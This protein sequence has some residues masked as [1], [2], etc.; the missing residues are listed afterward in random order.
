MGEHEIINFFVRNGN[1]FTTSNF[2]WLVLKNIE[3]ILVKALLWLANISQDFY[4]ICFKFLDFTTYGPVKNF[5]DEFKVGVVVVLAIS[6][7]FI[8]YKLL[9]HPDKKSSFLT[10]FMIGMFVLCA[11]ASLLSSINSGMIAGKDYVMNSYGASAS[12]ANKIISSNLTDIIYVDKKIGLKNMSPSNIPHASLSDDEIKLINYTEIVKDDSEFLTTNTAEDILKKKI[13]YVPNSNGSVSYALDD[14][15]D[16]VFTTDFGS[17]YYYRYHLN[18]LKVILSL[19]SLVIVFLVMGYKV[20]KLVWELVTSQF[21]VILFAGEIFSGQTM[22]KILDFVKNIYIVMLY[23]LVSI[24]MYLLA[25]DYINANITSGAG[26]IAILFLAFIVADGPVVVEKIL[27]I[28]AGLQ[29]GTGKMLAM[30]HMA[31]GAGRTAQNAYMQHRMNKN[32][33]DMTKSLNSSSSDSA[34]ENLFTHT[35]EANE[36][37]PNDLNAKSND[38]NGQQDNMDGMQ[39]DIS[40][41]YEKNDEMPKEFGEGQDDNGDLGYTSS[42]QQEMPHGFDEDSMSE[43]ELKDNSYGDNGMTNNV[44]FNGQSSNSLKEM[45]DFSG[46]QARGNRTNNFDT[47]GKEGGSTLDKQNAS[48]DGVR[49]QKDTSF[50]QAGAD[51]K[52]DLNIQQG[53]TG[54]IG[55]SVDKN[56]LEGQRDLSGTEI[57]DDAKSDLQGSKDNERGSNFGRDMSS[58]EGVRAQKDASFVQVEADKK[59]DLNSQ[60]EETGRIGQSVDKNGLEG[61]RDLS[62]TE[63]KDVEKDKTSGRSI[64]S[65][66]LQNDIGRKQKGKENPVSKGVQTQRAEIS[67]SQKSDKN[68]IAKGIKI[69]SVDTQKSSKIVQEKKGISPTSTLIKDSKKKEQ[70]LNG[71]ISK[72]VMPSGNNYENK[73]IKNQLNDD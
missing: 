68:S 7:L 63:M 69:E 21:L 39:G 40:G 22:K 16:G 54:R 52:G 51:K 60:Q 10:N 1:Y 48:L 14:V 67:R 29:S 43:D 59:G 70:N 23:T 33:R 13:V 71:G 36:N 46:S 17:E 45:K 5:L 15:Y 72:K 27:G 31:A 66:D 30:A 47:K 8:G 9:F 38:V 50:N 41:S 34:K 35:K 32:F 18:S 6:F 24:K 55:Q 11:S 12:A 26:T 37:M 42:N 62:G 4:N 49:A 25:V 44:I 19:L 57:K 61:Q 2:V 3:W 20:M 73:M 56:G 28:D 64:G 65:N 53:E 58:S